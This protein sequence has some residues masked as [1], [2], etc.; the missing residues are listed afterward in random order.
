[1]PQLVVNMKVNTQ[2]TISR[3]LKIIISKCGT[4]HIKTVVLNAG[5]RKT[6]NERNFVSK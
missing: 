2:N 5:K 3:N 4:H 6:K 1:M